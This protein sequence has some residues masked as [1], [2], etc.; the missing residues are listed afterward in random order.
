MT[1]MLSI[2]NIALGFGGWFAPV[3]L[4]AAGQDAIAVRGIDT[5]PHVGVDGQGNAVAV[6]TRSNG[7]NTIVQAA[8]RPAGGAW[9]A[10][11]NLSA[12]GQNAGAPHVAVDGQG[13]A[14]AV[15]TR[16]TGTN[17]IV[18]A[19]ARP[20]GGAWQ[21][22]INLPAADLSIASDP[23]V[24][25]DA[26]GN[27]VAV[28][29]QDSRVLAAARPA[30]GAW[31]APVNLHDP[32]QNAHF[33][34][35]AVNARGDVV[36]VWRNDDLGLAQAAVR[37]AGGAWQT[38]FT[39]SRTGSNAHPPQVAIDAQGNAVVVS[40]HFDGTNDI[41]QAAARPAG[42]A[43]QA[44]VALT[45][46]DV[47]SL[48]PQ[49][50][51]DA[52][53]NAVAVWLSSDDTTGD[54]TNAILHAAVRPAGGAWQAP[55]NL[56]AAGQNAGAPQVAVNAQGNAVAVWTRFDGTSRIVQGAVR[57]AGRAWQAPVDLSAAGQ[58]AVAPQVAVN[59]QGDAVTVWIRSNGTNDIVQAAVRLHDVA[60]VDL[61]A[62]G[63]D[64][65]APQVGVDAQGDAVAVWTRS[66]GTND[67]VQAAAR[68]AGGAWQAPITLSATGQNA[69]AP[70]VGVDAQ[71]DAVAVW[72]R[73][74]GT[75]D[76]VQA[77]ARPAGGTW[78][79]PITL[80]AAG[81]N[82]VAPQI[83]VDAQGNAVA[84]WTRFNGTNDIVQ[85][86][87]R[88]AGGAWQAPVDLSAAGQN[89]V[90]PQVGVDGQGDAVA[91]WIR[92][93]GITDV[94]QAAVRS[95][96]GGAWQA[97]IN[98]SA[99]GQNASDP[100][101]TVNAQ[102]NAVA[103]WTRSN[104]SNDIVQAAAR[105]GREAWQAPI[106]LAAAGQ[107]A[108]DPQVTVNAQGNAV[109]VWRRFNRSNWIVQAAATT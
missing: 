37:P 17:T 58:S 22:P 106:N 95:G 77:A 43:W 78:Q 46:N 53:G 35:I 19:A 54:F 62:T 4:S 89:A 34:Q 51:V 88:P 28:W 96:G 44:P 76:I 42:G 63:Q 90:A 40:E 72:T 16:D 83:G 86:A 109:A 70:Q 82:A 68:P 99:A 39:V 31:Q 49:V 55:I 52:R 67:I 36:A 61:S 38:P 18:Q 57:P 102:G 69:V 3:N 26:Q 94:V 56:S 6:W 92:S 103:V 79:A 21:A 32:N 100:Q 2:Q 75:N 23:Q 15:W 93:N 24:A 66:N 20:A 105:S 59:A 5:G 1:S 27:A 45:T 91:V 13:N 84:V 29:T 48:D 10:P 71:G 7:T 14:V 11:V 9:Q 101:V 107:N 41:V 33:P 85:A 97:P 30:G 12:A 80:S 65:L 104:G 8:A 50:A 60:P 47:R 81:Q 98:L 73:S 74:N 25:V 87:A 64:T 108:S